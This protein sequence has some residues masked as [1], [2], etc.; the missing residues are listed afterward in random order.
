MVQL[1]FLLAHCVH[2][3]GARRKKHTAY[4]LCESPM[5]T[6]E[7]VFDFSFVFSDTTYII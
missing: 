7:L 6:M 2:K 3:G 4:G 5:I 1:R